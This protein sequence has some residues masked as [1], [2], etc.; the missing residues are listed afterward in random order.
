MHLNFSVSCIIGQTCWTG[1]MKFL[2]MF[3]NQLMGK[4]GYSSMILCLQTMKIRQKQVKLYCTPFTKNSFTHCFIKSM[5]DDCGKILSF[6]LGKIKHVQLSFICIFFF[7]LLEK[8][9][10]I[11]AIMIHMLEYRAIQ[12]QNEHIKKT[13]M[14]LC[15]YS[16]F[17]SYALIRQNIQYTNN[18]T[19]YA[20]SKQ[21]EHI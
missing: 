8:R 7:I 10:P 9:V 11:L 1:L 17:R 5:V 20:I 21:N 12:K 18:K 19:L 4:H 13:G 16:E 3:P 2:L 6:F 14:S 15:C